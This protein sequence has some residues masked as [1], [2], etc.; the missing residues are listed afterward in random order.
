MQLQIRVM[1][2]MEDGGPDLEEVAVIDLAH[3]AGLLT[4][5]ESARYLPAITLDVA[6]TVAHAMDVGAGCAPPSPEPPTVVAPRLALVKAKPR[7]DD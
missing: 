1:L 7:D 5:R 4:R 2:S 6:R 3:L